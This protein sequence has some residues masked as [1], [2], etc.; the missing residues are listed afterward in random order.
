M[1][2]TTDLKGTSEAKLVTTT[3]V[4]SHTWETAAPYQAKCT[5]CGFVVPIL[6]KEVQKDATTQ[7]G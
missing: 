2:D 4:C 5:M 3:P 1:D 6:T 7:S